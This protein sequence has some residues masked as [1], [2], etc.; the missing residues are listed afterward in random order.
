MPGF[1]GTGP[2]GMGPMTGGG[3]GRCNPYLGGMRPPVAGGYP[4]YHAFGEGLPYN[5]GMYSTPFYGG[6]PYPPYR[7]YPYN[8]GGFGRGMGYG[9]GIGFGRGMGYG[10][11][12]G[13]G[14]RWW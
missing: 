2:R 8:V 14:R 12:M 13:M 6:Y 3:R 7:T 1:D 4:Y 9:R 10:R 5:Y 11:G